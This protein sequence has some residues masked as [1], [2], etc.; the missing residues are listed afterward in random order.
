[1]RNPNGTYT[2]VLVL[3]ENSGM[4]EDFDDEERF[5]EFM[6]GWQRILDFEAAQRKQKD[7]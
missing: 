6:R 5:R 7:T 1:M 2:A 3:D 4:I